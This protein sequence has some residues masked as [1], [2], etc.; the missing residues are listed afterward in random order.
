MVAVI[1][2]LAPAWQAQRTDP[3]DALRAE[4]RSGAG[5]QHHRLLRGLIV[6]EVALSLVLLLSAGLVLRGFRELVGR[7]PGFEPST[8]LTLDV[9]IPADRYEDRSTV[10]AFLQPALDAIRA[11]PG[12][13]NAAAI[14]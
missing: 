1:C 12:V 10:T 4:G 14:T 6:A 7:D 8:L 2:G 13:R 9:D 3:Q 11:L 5:S